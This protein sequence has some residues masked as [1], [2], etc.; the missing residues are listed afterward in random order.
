MSHATLIFNAVIQRIFHQWLQRQLQNLVFV[1]LFRYINL[2]FQDILIAELLNLK[3]A[4]DMGFFFLYCDV[5]LPLLNVV[6]K[7]SDNAVTI[8]ITCSFSPA[9][10]SQ[11]IASSVL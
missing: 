8:I 2:V 10:A 4:S 5:T 9:S 6:R 7:K 11:M 1:H 3:V